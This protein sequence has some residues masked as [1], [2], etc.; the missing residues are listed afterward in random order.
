MDILFSVGK[1]PLHQNASA[2]YIS[3]FS[4]IY[5]GRTH[6]RGLG[7]IVGSGNSSNSSRNY[8]PVRKSLIG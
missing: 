6:F 3:I 7:N 4:F 5:V 1:T 2:Q 8:S